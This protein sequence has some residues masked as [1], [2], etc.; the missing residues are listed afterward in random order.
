[1]ANR[2]STCSCHINPAVVWRLERSPP[3]RSDEATIDGNL[4][5]KIQPVTIF[6]EEPDVHYE[7]VITFR[8]SSS[9]ASCGVVL[10]LG[11]DYALGLRRD[12][13][14]VL[15]VTS[16]NLAR[17]WVNLSDADQ[18]L[19]EAEC[20]SDIDMCEGACGEFQVGALQFQTTTRS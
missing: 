9:S 11:S 12:D 6:K 16:C 5:Y 17:P 13:D 4:Y 7:N 14:G 10:E 3:R 18:A 15:S 20:E 19:L 8:T 2:P 1:M